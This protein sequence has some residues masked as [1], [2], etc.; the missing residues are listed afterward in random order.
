MRG[1]PAGFCVTVPHRTGHLGVPVLDECYAHFECRVANAMDT[2]SSTC[3]LG[4]VEA[5]GFGG[6]SMPRVNRVNQHTAS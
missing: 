4:D 6:T 5:T 3:F 1:G 2:G